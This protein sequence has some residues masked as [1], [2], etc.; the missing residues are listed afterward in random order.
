MNVSRLSTLYLLILSISKTFG[1]LQLHSDASNL[2]VSLA[3]RNVMCQAP[4]PNAPDSTPSQ[5]GGAGVSKQ[6]PL[7]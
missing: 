6:G 1:F 7:T 4:S 5:L 3:P 2:V